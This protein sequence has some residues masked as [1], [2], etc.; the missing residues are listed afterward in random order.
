M[1]ARMSRRALIGRQRGARRS[2]KAD[3]RRRRP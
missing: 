1:P 3:E 2:G